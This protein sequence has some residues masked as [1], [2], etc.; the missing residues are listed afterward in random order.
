MEEAE[1]VVNDQDLSI[2]TLNLLLL[3][4]SNLLALSVELMFK[5][6]N[7]GLALLQVGLVANA[8]LVLKFL[9]SLD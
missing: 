9:L 3:R 1:L 2:E 6:I 5:V 4:F 7:L 8:D